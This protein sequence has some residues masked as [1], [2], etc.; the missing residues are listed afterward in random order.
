MPHYLMNDREYLKRLWFL[1]IP[2]VLQYL[3]S[4]SVNLVDNVMVGSLGDV[5]MA[6]VSIGNQFFL[7]LF[8]I[9]IF[10]LVS[11]GSILNAQYWGIRDADRIHKVIGVQIL[12]GSL[13]GLIFSIATA[14]F[15][16]NIVALYS[17]D[18]AVIHS[19][20]IYMR[21]FSAV[22]LF[23]PLMMIFTG[24]QRSTGNTRLPMITSSF[25]LIIKLV[26]NYALIFG[27]FGFPKLG[28]LGCAYATLSARIIECAL[29]VFLSY[30]R[31]DPVSALPIAYF[32]FDPALT[33]KILRQTLPVIINEGI[34]GL[35]TNVYSAIYAK[36]STAS[37]AAVSAVNPIDN[38]MFTLFLGFG[39]ATGVMIGNALGRDDK[40]QAYDYGKKTIIL[41][42]LF[43]GVIGLAV[44]VFRAPILSL[45]Q[46]SAQAQAYASVL[47]TILCLS[48]WMRTIAYSLIIGVIRS[49]GDV[50]FSLVI[51]CTA[52]WAVGIPLSLL[53]AF[54]FHLPVTIVYF[55]FILDELLKVIVFSQRF[56]SKKWMNTLTAG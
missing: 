40:K 27:N 37:I 55:G 34:W 16:E 4:A 9:L 26:L 36:I 51:D 33:R 46:I 30:R 5:A 20:G 13:I 31:K 48:L 7:R 25:S 49:G 1:A 11:G 54:Y 41:S 15:S 17:N 42:G 21:S 38:L 24:G 23:Y 32:R 39:D 52:L 45:Y 18:P 53:L 35:G 6:S 2:L 8:H 44:L 10:G 19:G 3:I 28:V 12:V 56:I 22:Y 43:G 14:F 47:L 50:H 29:L